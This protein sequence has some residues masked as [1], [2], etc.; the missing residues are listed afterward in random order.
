MLLNFLNS[1]IDIMLVFFFLLT[2]LSVTWSKLVVS[3]FDDLYLEDGSLDSE[4]ILSKARLVSEVKQQSP[5]CLDIEEYIRVY[6]YFLIDEHGEEEQILMDGQFP[7][8]ITN[9]T[10]TMTNQEE[11]W[12]KGVIELR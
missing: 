6:E 2:S 12:I 5:D 11:P 9:Q 10:M 4:M 3:S 8:D 1:L 7:I